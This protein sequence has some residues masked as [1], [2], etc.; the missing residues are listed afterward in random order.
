MMLAPR[1]DLASG[2]HDARD[3]NGYPDADH[4]MAPL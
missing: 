2:G 4:A 3:D 1:I